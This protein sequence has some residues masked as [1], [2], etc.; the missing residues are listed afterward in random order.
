MDGMKYQQ[1][2]KLIKRDGCMIWEVINGEQWAG[3]RDALYCLEGMPKCQGPDEMLR[4]LG[5]ED[6]PENISAMGLTEERAWDVG[7]YLYQAD[8]PTILSRLA[9]RDLGGITIRFALTAGGITSI[10][11]ALRRPFARTGAQ[12]CTIKE[13]DDSMPIVAMVG[14]MPIA[15]I[16]PAEESNH[17][18][19][20]TNTLRTV[21]EARQREEQRKDAEKPEDNELQ[22]IGM[23]GVAQGEALTDCII[24]LGMDHMPACVDE[25]IDAYNG[26]RV[27]CNETQLSVLTDYYREAM[28]KFGGGE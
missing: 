16:W 23:E 19:D 3:P 2:G 26:A 15:I 9:Y 25:I 21:M 27:G 18:E 7:H 4:M 13:A 20:I 28:R 14:M 8:H 22:Q 11:D 12:L 17:G 6:E 24:G 10:D 1:I 5:V